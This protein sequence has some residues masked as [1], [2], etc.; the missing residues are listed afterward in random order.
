[1]TFPSGI[2]YLT[3][4]HNGNELCTVRV[5]ATADVFTFIASDGYSNTPASIEVRALDFFA[6]AVGMPL[7]CA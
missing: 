3:Y 1:M 6:A 4:E 5:N 2:A 7:G